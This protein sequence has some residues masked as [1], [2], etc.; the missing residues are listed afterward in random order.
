MLRQEKGITLVAL[1]VTIIVLIIL[2]AVSITALTGEHGILSEAQIARCMN[3]YNQ[4]DEQMKLAYTT[5]RTEITIGTARDATYNAKTKLAE[6]VNNFMT[7]DL[8]E[9]EYKFA[10]DNTNNVIYIKYENSAID[11]GLID[12]TS[13]PKVPRFNR[14]AYA[15]IAFTEQSAS[16]AFDIEKP[17]T[18]VINDSDW[19]RTVTVPTN[20]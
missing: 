20:P 4:A 3:A 15:S 2:A 5:V 18:S 17:S 12:N 13:D 1:I 6:Y 7:K 14:V 9:N 16:Y 19:S 11:Q 8:P 10:V